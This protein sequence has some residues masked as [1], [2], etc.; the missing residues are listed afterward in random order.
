VKLSFRRL[1]IVVVAAALGFALSPAL[2]A[3]SS[4]AQAPPAPAAAPAKPGVT[5]V[6]GMP[7]VIDP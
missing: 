2:R 1:C 3:Q 6:A 4:T 5:T 7:P